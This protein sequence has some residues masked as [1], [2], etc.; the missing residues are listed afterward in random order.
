MKS[1]AML[2]ASAAIM[3]ATPTALPAQNPSQVDTIE[4]GLPTQL[5]RT[6]VPHQY[7][8]TVTPHADRLSFDGSVAIDLDIVQPTATL[9]L[10]AADMTFGS[11]TLVPAAGGAPLTGR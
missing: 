1:V 2:L 10:N 11:A 6:A 9:V 8:I 3:L 4:T 5:P 7:A